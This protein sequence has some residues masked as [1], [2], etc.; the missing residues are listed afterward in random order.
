MNNDY[1]NIFSILS[2]LFNTENDVKNNE[3]NNKNEDIINLIKSIFMPYISNDTELNNKNKT[4]NEFA[5]EKNLE[6]LL[7]GLNLVINNKDLIS[8]LLNSTMYEFFSNKKEKTEEVI[9]ESESIKPSNVK[10][11]K[12]TDIDYDEMMEEFDSIQSSV[13]EKNNNLYLFIEFN[14]SMFSKNHFLGVNKKK[15]V[16][17][18]DNDNFISFRSDNVFVNLKGEEV[19]LSVSKKD[20]KRFDEFDSKDVKI[21][22]KDDK[23]IIVFKFYNS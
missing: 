17:Y 21:K 6:G 11:E 14:N 22:Y 10:K 4:V 18:N 1:Q 13:K 3:T 16:T 19:Q 5:K 15:N 20:V 2:K 9:V 23:T 12:H 7:F 8:N